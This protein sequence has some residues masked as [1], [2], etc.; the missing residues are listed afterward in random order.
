MARDSVFQLR[1]LSAKRDVDLTYSVD[2]YW[3]YLHHGN[4][5]TSG[6]QKTDGWAVDHSGTSGDGAVGRGNWCTSAS[7]LS[8]ASAVSTG[9][10]GTSWSGARALGLA[11]DVLSANRWGR[12]CSG[13]GRATLWLPI[14]VLGAHWCGRD[15]S[16]GGAALW[17]PVNILG[18][19]WCGR[20]RSGGR[21]A[22]WLTINVLGTDWSWYIGALQIKR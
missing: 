22:L 7:W 2:R 6:G 3:R 19:H 13:G 12:R 10:V 9:W 17:L 5:E 11:V 14:N 15:W 20:N 21:A 4:S 16:S 18:A 1:G 8:D